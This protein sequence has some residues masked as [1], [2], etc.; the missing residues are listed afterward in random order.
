M[1]THKIIFSNKLRYRVGRHLLLWMVFCMY[2]FVVNFFPRN[3]QEIFASHTY[4]DAFKR[5]I[6]LPVSIFSVY[7]ATYYLLPRFILTGRYF[8]FFAL[9]FCLCVINFVSA[10]LLTMLWVQ[11]SQHIPFQ[12]A[13]LQVRLFQPLIYGFGL[14]LASSGFAIIIKIIKIRHLKQ[15]ENERL[16]EQKIT[17]ELQM[18]KTNF[19][20]HFLSAALQNISDL[21]RNHSDQSASVILKLSELL[22]YILY[23]NE[24]ES[25]PLDQEIL[26]IRNYLDL[27]KT[28]YGNRIVTS[29]EEKGNTNGKKIAPLVFLSLVQNCG[30]QFLISLQQK[31]AIDIQI[32]AEENGIIFRLSCNGYYESINGIPR[33][34]TGLNQALRRIQ[35]IYPERHKLETNTENGIFSMTL[36]LESLP[37]YKNTRKKEKE[38]LYES[39]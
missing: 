1:I 23:E 27:E 9:F 3:A 37:A 15:K 12:Q 34:N 31:L 26:M 14:G 4:M 16:L 38:V 36:I 10:Y 8:R 18:I 28:F 33:P 30:E 22:S 5:L 39:A 17:T 11:F 24:E 35:M 21:I 32:N 20:P 29:L 13:P 7:V 19:H 6:Y 2:V 25:I